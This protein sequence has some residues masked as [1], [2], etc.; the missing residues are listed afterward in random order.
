MWEPALPAMRRA[1]GA[2]SQERQKNIAMH[3]RCAVRTALDLENARRTSPCT[4][5]APRGRRSI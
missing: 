5:D 3:P 2:R 4:R 1:D